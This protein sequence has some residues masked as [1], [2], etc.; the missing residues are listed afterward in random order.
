MK[1]RHILQVLGAVLLFGVGTTPSFA[2]ILTVDA[3]DGSWNFELEQGDAFV[4]SPPP[5]N[6]QVAWGTGDESIPFVNFDFNAAYGPD[7]S[8]GNPNFSGTASAYLLSTNQ[9]ITGFQMIG[10]WAWDVTIVFFQITFAPN[11]DTGFSG[12]AD[13]LFN[14]TIGGSVEPLTVNVTPVPEPTT[15]GLLGLAGGLLA[16]RRRK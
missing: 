14:S 13:G 10:P 2:S 9:E 8:E 5:N 7:F 15:L 11:F 16:W 6:Q 3:N 1:S 12:P 4:A